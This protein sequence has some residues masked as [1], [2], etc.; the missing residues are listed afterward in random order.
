MDIN[1]RIRVQAGSLKEFC[2]QIFQKVGVLQEDARIA[3]GVLVTADLRGIESHGVA[4]LRNLYVNRLLAGVVKPR[5]QFQIVKESPVSAVVDGGAGLG[6]PTANRAMKLAIEKACQV[7]AGFVTVRNSNHFGIAGYYAMMALEHGCIGLTM[8]NSSRW[9][10]PTF[11]KDPM[12]GTNPIA[13]AVPA[14]KELPFVL[15]M[16]TSAVSVG[17][18]EV[19]DRL[20][21]S[22]PFGWATDQNGVTI[23]DPGAVLRNVRAGIGGGLLPL[24]GIGEMLGGHKGYGL[25]VWADIFSALLSG[26]MYADQVYG[27]DQDTKLRAG[28]IG[29]FFGA[30]RIDSFRPINEFQT[31]M[32]DLL[33]RLKNSNKSEGQDR[34]YVAGEKEFEETER[35]LREGI[36][37]PIVVVEDLQRLGSDFGIE[38]D[39]KGAMQIGYGT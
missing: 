22:I 9:V 14:G 39:I 36:P 8:T 33:L 4:R 27:Q 24:G 37:V 13:V 3:A 15:D 29:H 10:V 1:H 28:N 12:L 34:I 38:L 23:S 5:P 17:K 35:R 19:H 16:A 31:A 30:W 26:A 7:G 2:S 20:G 11:G 18:I 6:H 25:A 32:D 21:D